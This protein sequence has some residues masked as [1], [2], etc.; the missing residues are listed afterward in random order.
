VTPLS[1]FDD[2]G[3]RLELDRRARRRLLPLLAVGLLLACWV[4]L[5]PAHAWLAFPPA[6]VLAVLVVW[7][8]W[9]VLREELGR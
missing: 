7:E 2:E 5:V 8:A 6:M 3:R 1:T 4:E 9:A